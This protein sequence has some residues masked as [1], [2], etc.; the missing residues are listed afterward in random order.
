MLLNM[1]GSWK[2]AQQ[3][4]YFS[5]GCKWNY[6]RTCTMKHYE[7]WKV[8]NALLKSVCCVAEYTI[9][10]LVIYLFIYCLLTG[11]LSSWIMQSWMFLWLMNWKE[12]GRTRSY[13]ALRYHSAFAFCSASCHFRKVGP[14]CQQ[15]DRYYSVIKRYCAPFLC[16]PCGCIKQQ[17]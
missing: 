10:S 6:M 1:Y 15:D 7:I 12:C 2:L 9:G 5:D 16:W 11:G 14:F 8:K 17:I 4:L 13:L 3:R